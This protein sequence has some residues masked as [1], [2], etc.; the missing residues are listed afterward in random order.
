ML[1]LRDLLDEP[2]IDKQNVALKRAFNYASEPVCVDGLV[3]EVILILANV[4]VKLS[5]QASLL[6]EKAG[7]VKLNSVEWQERCCRCIQFLHTH[8]T[9]YPDCRAHGV[10][11]AFNL[12]ALPLEYLCSSINAVSVLA[13]SHNSADVNYSLFWG[14]SF[15]F[16]GRITSL[17]QEIVIN[18]NPQWVTAF[19]QL[20]GVFCQSYKA[21]ELTNFFT[22]SYL[23]AQIPVTFTRQLL[24]P[25]DDTYLSVTPIASH[26][27]QQAVHSLLSAQSYFWSDT[28][29]SDR[30]SNIG[31]FFAATGG[32]I[33]VIK[34]LPYRLQASWREAA[35]SGWLS[36]AG[37]RAL[38]ALCEKSDIIE[39]YKQK[40][41]RH[42]ELLDDLKAMIAQW[43]Q[44]KSKYAGCVEN[45]VTQLSHAFHADL[46][47]TKYGTKLA[48]HPSALQPVEATIISSLNDHPIVEDIATSKDIAGDFIL[49]PGLRV[50]HANAQSCP[51]VVGLPSLTAFNGF[52]HN[53]CR[54]LAVR[55]GVS[56]QH[57]G[58]VICLHSYSFHNRGLTQ[59]GVYSKEK[60]RLVSPATISTRQCDLVFSMVLKVSCDLPL[61]DTALLLSAL[62][63]QFAGGSLILSFDYQAELKA[64]SSLQAAVDQ[65]PIAN[66]GFLVAD[67]VSPDL[68]PAVN[69]IKDWL[70][71][72][73]EYLKTNKNALLVNK[74][75]LLLEQPTIRE[76]AVNEYRH[77][78]AEFVVGVVKFVK[79]SEVNEPQQLLWQQNTTSS[80]VLMQTIEE[81]K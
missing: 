81:T 40:Q 50:T 35:D 34:S 15:I 65:I 23:P 79:L 6:D 80:S 31:S 57:L 32:K 36:T 13:Y 20:G 48:Y 41:N 37:L 43:Y 18:E 25:F 7:V 74:G 4:T 66:G 19:T 73:A 69:D 21:V 55:L 56:I 1:L 10:V 71:F 47:K 59:E 70:T 17:L 8:N 77:C 16:E 67:R 64:Y 52:A 46:A 28:M 78:F 63:A 27:V 2:D 72:Y 51:Y 76:G 12:P 9:K 3:K 45:D 42:S 26:S 62:P 75:Y 68:L 60:Q 39:T 58:T 49:L 14:A 54:R 38:F 11:R 61:T 53:Y 44:H 22:A 29:R 5:P 33:K 24:V 30:A